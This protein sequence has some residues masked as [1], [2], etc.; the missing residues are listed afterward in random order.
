MADPFIVDPRLTLGPAH[1]A[2]SDMPRALAFYEG[3]LGLHSTGCVDGRYCLSAGTTPLLVLEP[4]ASSRAR[5]A[6]STGL[7]HVA[8]LLPTR[9]DLART[10]TRLSEVRYPLSGASDHRVSEALYLDD[11]D[12]NG[13]EIYVDRPR[14]AW[15]RVGHEL[16]MTVDPLDI[17]SIMAELGRDAPAW[18]GLPAGTTVGHIHLQV[19][20]LRTAEQFYV[21]LLGLSVMQRFSGSALFVAAGGYHHHLGLNTWA[22]VGAPL[23]P[24][25]AP[26]LRHMVL[27]FPD[28]A[29]LTAVEA[30][31]R[32]AEL[33]VEVRPTGLFLRDPSQHGLLLTVAGG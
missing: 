13:L 11:P 19:A 14:D 33:S 22:G 4:G 17:V 2:V 9:S 6:R 16:R 25:D 21:G 20:D 27:Q 18:T 32:K 5:P 15:P 12:G 3:L 26:G 23:P 31:L 28:Q 29:T 10:I 24:P 30:R 1:L 8:L 7:Y